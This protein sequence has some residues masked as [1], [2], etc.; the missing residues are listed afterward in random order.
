MAAGAEGEGRDER[1]RF[2]AGNRG[3]A[4]GTRRR[5]FTL[6]RA[7]EEA[8]TPEHVAAMIRKATRM[9]LEGDLG[10]IRLVLD[11]VCGRPDK[12]PAEPESIPLQLPDLRSAAD[13]NAAVDR[14]LDATLQGAIDHEV[15]KLLLEAIRIRTRAIELN[16]VQQEMADLRG[17]LAQIERRRA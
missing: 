2:T 15:A 10:A 9:G 1:G 16:E 12:M 13:C 4:G 5:A 7:A 8:I 6:R 14:V 3:G 17:L 11:R